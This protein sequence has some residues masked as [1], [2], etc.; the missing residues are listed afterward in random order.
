MMVGTW[1]GMNFHNMP[2]L[3]WQ[4]GY[5]VAGIVTVIST[6]L[7]YWYFKKKNWF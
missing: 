2:E 5:L 7:T 1:Y 6:T 4:H 3:S